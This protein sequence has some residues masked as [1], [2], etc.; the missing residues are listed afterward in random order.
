[1]YIPLS[2]AA[3]HLDLAPKVCFAKCISPKVLKLHQGVSVSY[4]S[5]VERNF[6]KITV[7]YSTPYIRTYLYI[8]CRTYLQSPQYLLAVQHTCAIQVPLHSCIT[9]TCFGGEARGE[10]FFALL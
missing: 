3:T 6:S 2:R 10:F 8:P 1:M 4:L 5:H 7:L 9:Q